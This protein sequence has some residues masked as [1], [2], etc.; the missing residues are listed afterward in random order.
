MNKL[1][2]NDYISI[3]LTILCVIFAFWIK[4]Y[5]AALAWCVVILVE[6]TMFMDKQHKHDLELNIKLL[7]NTLLKIGKGELTASIIEKDGNK[8]ILEMTPTQIA[9]DKYE[10]KIHE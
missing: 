9:K 8:F 5:Y 2:T 6:F 3:G 10:N 1:L 4:N 7:H